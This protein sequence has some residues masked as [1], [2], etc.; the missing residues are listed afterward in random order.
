MKVRKRDG[1]RDIIEKC[2]GERD[3]GR[4]GGD[5]DREIE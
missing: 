3:I 5:S 2:E 4:G 1:D